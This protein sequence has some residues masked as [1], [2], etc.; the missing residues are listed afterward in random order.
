M[1]VRI[2]VEALTKQKP[3]LLVFSFGK[4]TSIRCTGCQEFN[5]I[6]FELKDARYGFRL[7]SAIF[8][9]GNHS[10]GTVT[11]WLPSK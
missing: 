4:N 2:P 3:F 7:K 5:A 6:I 11:Q 9:P 10:L 8:A 1:E